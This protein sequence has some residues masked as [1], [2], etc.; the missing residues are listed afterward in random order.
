MSQNESIYW[1]QERK[2]DLNSSRMS[3]LNEKIG[4]RLNFEPDVNQVI[5][6]SLSEK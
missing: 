1:S 2:D 4:G 6:R 3:D 5:T